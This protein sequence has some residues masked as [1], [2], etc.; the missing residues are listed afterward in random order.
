MLLLG[1]VI[2]QERDEEIER[3]ELDFRNN[4]FASNPELYKALFADEMRA[5]NS[6]EWI[7]P[8]S[9]EDFAEMLDELREFGIQI[10]ED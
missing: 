9:P 1:Y 10:D 2:K 8:E 6:D 3:F 4:V 7:T 5:T